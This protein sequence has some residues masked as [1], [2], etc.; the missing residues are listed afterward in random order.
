MDGFTPLTQATSTK[1]LAPAKP[2]EWSGLRYVFRRMGA[3]CVSVFHIPF[4]FFGSI[5]CFNDG[6]HPVTTSHVTTNSFKQSSER[7][8]GKR[9]A[10]PARHDATNHNQHASCFLC[11]T[12]RS[13]I[14]VKIHHSQRQQIRNIRITMIDNLCIQNFPILLGQ[15]ET[16]GK[17]QK[18]HN[19]SPMFARTAAH[20]GVTSYQ[21]GQW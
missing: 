6:H 19:V 21:F 12:Q 13:H 10:T 7:E 11:P 18:G 2:T 5:R 3:A 16:V 8:R 15:R 20:H 17:T 14:N 4:C 9:S 1:A